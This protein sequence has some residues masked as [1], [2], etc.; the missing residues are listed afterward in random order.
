M[1]EVRFEWTDWWNRNSGKA[2]FGQPTETD[3]A[4]GFTLHSSVFQSPSDAFASMGDVFFSAFFPPIDKAAERRD[5]LLHASDFMARRAGLV[6]GQTFEAKAEGSH[7]IKFGFANDAAF[8][9]FKEIYMHLV[10]R[11]RPAMNMPCFNQPQEADIFT[12]PARIMLRLL[13]DRPKE[14]EEQAQTVKQHGQRMIRQVSQET[15]AND[16]HFRPAARVLAFGNKPV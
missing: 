7:D 9:A 2:R 13:A 5:M 16:G 6:P 10:H 3:W 15:A 1:S 12:M 4:V 11:K 8:L 14:P